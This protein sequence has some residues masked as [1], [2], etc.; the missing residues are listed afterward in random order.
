MSASHLTDDLRITGLREISPPLEVHS[1]LPI[2]DTAAETIFATR[3]AIHRILT[4]EDDRLLA[5]VG[6]CSIHDTKA[7]LE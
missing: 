3:Q 5:I 1:E 6:P 7:A 2:T 4:G